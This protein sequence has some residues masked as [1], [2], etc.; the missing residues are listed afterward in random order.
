M[1]RHGV[2]IPLTIPNG[3]KTV[4]FK[5]NQAKIALGAMTQAT[6]YCPGTLPETVTVKIAQKDDPAAGDYE[7][8]YN[9][10]DVVAVAAKAVALPDFTAEA[11]ELSSGTNVGADRVFYLVLQLVGDYLG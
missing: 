6:L 10:A 11:L 8:L 9:G 2:T 3:T 7:T 1:P 5:G 4:E